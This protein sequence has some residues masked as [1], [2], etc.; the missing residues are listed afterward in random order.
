MNELERLA[1]L[2]A[3]GITNFMPRKV[4]PNA[5]VAKACAWHP[6]K[7]AAELAHELALEWRLLDDAENPLQ[8][9]AV[10]SDGI[11]NSSPQSSSANSPPIT[12]PSIH[13]IAP[14]SAKAAI[15]VVEPKTT[16]LT[17]A[18]EPETATK[19]S[20]SFQK[21]SNKAI[22]HFALSVWRITDDW[23]VIDSRHSELALPTEAFLL[24]I[25]RALNVSTQPYQ[26]LPQTQVFRWP[27]L[28]DPLQ[29][30]RFGK[31][32]NQDAEAAK[33]ALSGFLDEQ[34][35]LQPA[36]YLWLMG[37]EAATYLLPDTLK[38]SVQSD[39]HTVGYLNKTETLDDWS[40][41]VFCSPS[42]SELLMQPEQKA[43]LWQEWHR[44]QSQ[45]ENTQ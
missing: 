13:S 2:Q 3:M 12:A 20:S 15:P 28:K 33:E 10:S 6:Q 23:L 27:M 18:I 29:A 19:T 40:I 32:L 22:P 14:S 35:V 11:A 24:N 38:A 9:S 34:L 44:W 16:G 26:Q 39:T 4:L 41:K 42:L 21:S 8:S 37:E 5:P 45:V 17:N 7:W 43:G 30:R 31:G 36:R 25:I 1:Y